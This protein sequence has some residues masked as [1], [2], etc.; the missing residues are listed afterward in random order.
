MAPESADGWASRSSRRYSC[1]A[2]GTS[3]GRPTRGDAAD[4]HAGGTAASPGAQAIR[5]S[6]IGGGAEA[7]ATG[8]AFLLGAKARGCVADVA[9]TDEH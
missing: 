2:P 9:A 4:R 5:R 8:S 3:R 1:P 7:H 6:A